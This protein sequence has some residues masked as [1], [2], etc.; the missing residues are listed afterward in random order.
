MILF[1]SASF[2]RR[3]QTAWKSNASYFLIGNRNLFFFA[4]DSLIETATVSAQSIDDFLA[5]DGFSSGYEFL[6]FLTPQVVDLPGGYLRV[7]THGSLNP[8]EWSAF[9]DFYEADGPSAKRLEIRVAES[10]GII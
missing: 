7:E 6:G 1:I 8:L 2:Q 4:P 9:L 10:H 5:K 3:L